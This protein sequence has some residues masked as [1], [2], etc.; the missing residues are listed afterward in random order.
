MKGIHATVESCKTVLFFATFSIKAFCDIVLKLL[1]FCFFNT[2]MEDFFNVGYSHQEEP[3]R[4]VLNLATLAKQ[5][6]VGISNDEKS[7]T[8][9]ENVLE[10]VDKPSNYLQNDLSVDDTK[11]KLPARS[12]R[13]SIIDAI[14]KRALLQKQS[15][16]S[17]LVERI[18]REKI[19]EDTQT[20]N[21]QDRPISNFTTD[22]Y[23][24][25]LKDLGNSSEPDDSSVAE[26]EIRHEVLQSASNYDESNLKVVRSNDIDVVDK[27]LRFPEL[28][29]GEIEKYRQRYLLRVA[30]KC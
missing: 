12:Q 27:N 19:M 22:A 21:S 1:Q 15:K 4:K 5:V 25:I 6:P 8:K 18:R 23:Q 13:S 20:K 7:Q 9:E 29:E 17:S 26:D 10:S 11:R 16:Q 3:V 24:R 2:S 30:K 28:T 14:S